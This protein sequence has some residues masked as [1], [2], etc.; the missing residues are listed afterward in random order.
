MSQLLITRHISIKKY[1][2]KHLE[3]TRLRNMVKL[4]CLFWKKL[5]LVIFIF[6][7]FSHYS[8]FYKKKFFEIHLNKRCASEGKHWLGILF[9]IP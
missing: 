6:I 9:S 1:L 3:G 7:F 4:L 2:T 5:Y 8:I